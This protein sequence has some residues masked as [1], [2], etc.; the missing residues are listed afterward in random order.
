MKNILITGSTKGLGLFLAQQIFPDENLILCGSKIENLNL[1][2]EKMS[3]SKS[4][5]FFQVDFLDN[6]ETQLFCEEVEK[7]IGTPDV[8]I[9]CLGA[10][11]GTSLNSELIEWEKVIRLNLLAAVQINNF[12]IPKMKYL[13]ES[14]II[15]VSSMAS[16]TLDGSAPYIIAKSAL[17]TY[18]KILGMQLAGSNLVAIGVRPG[19]IEIP[20]RYLTKL[21]VEDPTAFM[22]WVKEHRL[23]ENRLCTLED[24]GYMVKFLTT[25]HSSYMN[26]SIIDMFG[27]AN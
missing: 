22:K 23:R 19:P 11:F 8:I 24:I 9:H 1:A 15:L 5:Q 2:K 4:T 6:S 21:Q 20:E 26:G 25:K 16:I 13:D 12:F 14:R 27:G 10:S 18:V 3:K 17:D 7:K